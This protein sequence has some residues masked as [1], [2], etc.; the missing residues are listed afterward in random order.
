MVGSP[1]PA[2]TAEAGDPRAG[3]DWLFT[4]GTDDSNSALT[5]ASIPPTPQAVT[6]DWLRHMAAGAAASGVTIEYAMLGLCGIDI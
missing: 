4:T 3:W 6:E 1:R 5:A 2:P